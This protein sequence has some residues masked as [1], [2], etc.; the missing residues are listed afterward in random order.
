M[1]DASVN[2]TLPRNPNPANGRVLLV[3]SLFP[4]IGLL[5]MAFEEAGFCV[6]R[7]PDLLWGGDIRRFHPPAGRFDGVI[8]GPPCQAFSPLR[9]LVEHAGGT[10]ADNMIPEF[11]RVISQARPAWFVMENVPAAP[12]P[13]VD[14]FGTVDRIIKDHWCGGETGR[15]RRFT[16]GLSRRFDHGPRFEVPTLALHTMQ[17]APAVLAAGFDAGGKRGRQRRA[18]A[19]RLGFDSLTTVDAAIRLSGLPADFL[20]EAPFTVSGKMKAI[21]NGVPLAMGRA[22]AVAVH[23]EL[24][25]QADFAVQKVTA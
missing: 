4:G 25:R 13:R 15:E 1:S 17:P 7:G 6:V 19:E 18:Q 8:G 12:L 5:D 11:E 14:G 23:R 24:A 22:V 10:L 20:K 21:G 9:K 3:L 2:A 16:F